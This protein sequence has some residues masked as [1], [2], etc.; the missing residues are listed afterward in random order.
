M[1]Y[2]EPTIAQACFGSAWGDY[3]MPEYVDALFRRILDEIKRVYWNVNQESWDSCHCTENPKIEGIE[4]RP[5]YWGDCDCGFEEED[6]RWS[7]EHEH[8]TGCFHLRYRQEESVCCP[9]FGFNGDKFMWK[10]EHMTEWARANG[11]QR[12]PL[13]MAVYCDCGHDQEYHEWRR[14]HDHKPDCPIVLPNFKFEDVEIRWY[15]Y[16][17]RGMSTNKVMTEKEWREWFDM[18][19]DV[20]KKAD[21]DIFEETKETQEPK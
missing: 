19:L 18:C 7:N 13:G 3:E 21:V 6:E 9:P 2:Y 20:I 1:S 14:G 8:K 16:T 4:I 17:G 10:H 11:Y 5:Y 15:K 12:A